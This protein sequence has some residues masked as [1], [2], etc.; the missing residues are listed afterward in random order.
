MTHSPCYDEKTHTPCDHREFCIKNGRNACEAWVKYEKLHQE[1]KE[2][3]YKDT[4]S[5]RVGNSYARYNHQR[6]MNRI[7][8]S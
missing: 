4:L 2:Q 5:E 8:N 1:E 3:M 7:K 6:I